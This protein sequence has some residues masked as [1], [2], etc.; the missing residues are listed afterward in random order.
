MTMEL[1]HITD[2]EQMGSCICIIKGKSWMNGR[3][4][5]E[6]VETV[7]TEWMGNVKLMKCLSNRKIKYVNINLVSR[8]FYPLTQSLFLPG[9]DYCYWYEVSS[10]MPGEK[11]IKL[12][13]YLF[14]FFLTRVFN[15]VRGNCYK[16]SQKKITKKSKTILL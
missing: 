11:T 9:F 3:H 15:E 14:V 4:S 13:I 6:S 7:K 8:V 1:S 16:T 10:F 12:N 5:N 2:I